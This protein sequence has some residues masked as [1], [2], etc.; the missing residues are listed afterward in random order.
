MV[1]LAASSTQIPMDVGYA[2]MVPTPQSWVDLEDCRQDN[3]LLHGGPRIGVAP[4]HTGVLL[5]RG[6][7]D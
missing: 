3:R 2:R 1:M 4:V 7:P 5:Y 6:I